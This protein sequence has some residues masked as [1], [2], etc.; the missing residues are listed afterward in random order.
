MHHSSFLESHYIC[1]AMLHIVLFAY[2]IKLNILTKNKVT[3]IL[4]KKLYCAIQSTRLRDIG[5]LDILVNFAYVY[6]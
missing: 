4:P 6:K 5:N 1:N 3:N 2:A